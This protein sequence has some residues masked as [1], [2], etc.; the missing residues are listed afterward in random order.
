MS[1]HP[2]TAPNLIVSIEIRVKGG[3]GVR[4]VLSIS[5]TRKEE[6]KHHWP[7][8]IA[9]ALKRRLADFGVARRANAMY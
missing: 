6:V 1:T 2:R 4:R 3:S 8:F 7:G 9:V 5:V